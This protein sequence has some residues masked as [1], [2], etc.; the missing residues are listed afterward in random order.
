MHAWAVWCVFQIDRK[1]RGGVGDLPF[2]ERLLHKLLLNFTWWVNRKDLHG[3]NVFQGGFL[4]PHNIGV[5]D[6]NV[7]VA[8][9]G[10][11]SQA[12]VTRSGW[13]CTRSNLLP[14]CPEVGPAQ[15]RL[16]RHRHQVLRTLPAKSPARST[17][18]AST[19]PL[20]PVGPGRSSSTT[21]RS[22]IPTVARWCCK[23][24]RSWD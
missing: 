14:H 8:R 15:P 13:P 9:G 6:R 5:F 11:L 2:L 12:D 1:L 20:G 3:R 21:T 4:G 18:S 16:R 10:Y 17:T 7:P 24:A 22:K 23:S 19:V